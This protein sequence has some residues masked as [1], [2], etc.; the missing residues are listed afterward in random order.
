MFA[1]WLLLMHV[2]QGCKKYDRLHRLHCVPCHINHDPFSMILKLTVLTVL[3]AT[4]QKALG[5]NSSHP[6]GI[7]N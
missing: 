5:I 6:Q 3:T 1:S 4:I 2:F 7:K